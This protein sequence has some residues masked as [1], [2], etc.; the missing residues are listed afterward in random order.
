MKSLLRKFVFPAM[1]TIGSLVSATAVNAGYS[2]QVT[3]YSVYQTTTGSFLFFNMNLSHE[4]YGSLYFSVADPKESV[5]M[6]VS[7]AV[8]DAGLTHVFTFDSA[9]S[10]YQIK[11]DNSLLYLPFV[12]YAPISVTGRVVD[13]W[14]SMSYKGPAGIQKVVSLKPELTG[15]QPMIGRAMVDAMLRAY[16]GQYGV[17]F[18]SKE[19]PVSVVSVP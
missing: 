3:D 16:K 13:G 15:Y 10:F 2:G 6:V 4:P 5:V 14:T 17:V 12:P 19:Q 8:R 18:N 7:A 1:L 9:P 11:V